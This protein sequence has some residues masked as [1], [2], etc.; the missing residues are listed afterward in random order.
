MTRRSAR[1]GLTLIELVIYMG[2]VTMGLL[3][4]GNVEMAAQRSAGMQQALLDIEDRGRSFSRALRADLEASAHVRY[5]ADSDT[6]EIRRLDG[7]WIYYGPGRR[8]ERAEHDGPDLLLDLYGGR[9]D[10]WTVDRTRVRTARGGRAVRWSV[11][12]SLVV[13]TRDGGELRRARRLSAVARREVL[14]G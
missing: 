8:A 14:G 1:R 2:L 5:L 7:R 11:E 3:L 13:P 12:I 10:G 4:I 9:I 6:L